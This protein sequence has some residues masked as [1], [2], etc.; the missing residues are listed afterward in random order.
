MRGGGGG[1]I[2]LV[3]I[4][5]AHEAQIYA[6]NLCRGMSVVGCPTPLVGLPT[7]CRLLSTA[8]PGS[9]ALVHERVDF[10]QGGPVA[11]CAS[12]LESL[13]QCFQRLA[14]EDPIGAPQICGVP[15]HMNPV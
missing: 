2:H 14:L 8:R 11:R 10:V 1:P 9:A 13:E 12:A 5:G 3:V 4:S 7:G 15:A 6:A